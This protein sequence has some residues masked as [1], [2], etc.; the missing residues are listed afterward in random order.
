MI[1]NL[2]YRRKARLKNKDEGRK[3]MDSGVVTVGTSRSDPGPMGNSLT[4]I[5]WRPRGISA[6]R[7]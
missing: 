6:T 7:G 3:R 5:R 4:P 1:K 2:W